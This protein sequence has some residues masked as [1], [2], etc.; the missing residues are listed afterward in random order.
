MLTA[1]YAGKACAEVPIS[2]LEME[3]SIGVEESELSPAR[4][5]LLPLL[6]V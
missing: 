3:A 1:S 2:F 4:H 6:L 5:E